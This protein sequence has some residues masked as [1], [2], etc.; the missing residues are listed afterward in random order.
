MK[1]RIHGIKDGK[2]NI[3]LSDNVSNFPNT[4]PEFIGDVKVEGVLTKMRNRFNFTGNVQCNSKLICDISLEE[5]EQQ[6]SAQLELNYIV[7]SNLF[8]M[9]KDYSDDGSGE[10]VIPDDEEFVDIT[11]DVKDI[12]VVSLPMKKVSPKY[13][14]KSFSEIYPQYS[15]AKKD[16]V[17]D[18]RWA[19]LKNISFD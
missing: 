7:D 11:E 10:I 9:K 2:H 4:F 5:F 17:V 15:S 13:I 14:G 1:I 16:D 19:G 12:L 3:E 18:D 8:F 6:I